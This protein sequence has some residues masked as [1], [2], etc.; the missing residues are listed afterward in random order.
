[1]ARIRIPGDE[2]TEVITVLARIRDRLERV[3]NLESVGTEDDVGDR[4]LVG[5][6]RSFDGAWRDGHERVRENTDT[7]REM[8]EGILENFRKADEETVAAL[9]PE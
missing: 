9:E 6:V 3:A 8:V 1:M 4:A 7:F 5:G 2:L